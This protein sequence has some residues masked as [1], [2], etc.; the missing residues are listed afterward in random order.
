LGA[1]FAFLLLAALPG[2][3][4][5]NLPLRYSFENP[6]G[7]VPLPSSPPILTTVAEIRVY[8]EN[9]TAVAP[10]DLVV[11]LD[12]ADTGE[13]GWEDLLT[14]IKEVGKVVKL[15]LSACTMSGTEFDPGSA[16]TGEEFITALTL[17][18]G[19]AGIVGGT[20]ADPTFRYFTALASA[21]GADI[22]SV[23][24]Y[25]FYGCTAL[26]TVSFPAAD[27]IGPAAFYN[28]TSLTTV[29]LPEARTI[30][31]EAFESC[32][33]LTT[34]ALPKAETINGFA[35]FNCH[36]LETVNLPAAVA[37][38][39]AVFRNCYNLETV[40]LPAAVTI[41]E[42]VFA[43]CTSLTTVTLPASLTT[44]GVRAFTYCTGLTTVTLPASLTAIGDNPFSGCT[45][46]T[47]LIV[48]VGN[49]DY[50]AE[51]G[52]LLTK[53]GAT[54]ISC[55]SGSGTVTLD[56]VTTIGGWAFADCTAL[57]EVNLPSAE[58]IG[59][60]AFYR[61]GT[62][63]L[64]VTLPADAPT[65]AAGDNAYATYSRTVTVKA[66]AVRTGY[67][68][69]WESKFKTAFGVNYDIYIVTI[70]L[71]VTDTP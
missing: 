12:L 62:D 41:S 60:N 70:T 44:L 15:D 38:G 68:G 27:F 23:G 45:N 18:D 35:F 63:T 5:Y 71:T 19:A 24:N 61:T 42:R 46:L 57:T 54:L 33:S 13:N 6:A 29:D 16:D 58:D 66:P 34:V 51:N 14:V 17:P 50:K 55:P 53:D 48:D 26:T 28:C 8:L 40:S 20:L 2:C 21:S 9:A 69:A 59:V 11:K 32:T 39:E 22:T 49:P 56:G 1:V 65:V 25:A 10:V 7:G 52:M 36:S 30:R 37:I 43:Y 4:S 67:N 47:N 64:I 3:D 31:V